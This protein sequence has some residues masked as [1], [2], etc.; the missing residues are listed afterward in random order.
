MHFLF[1]RRILATL[2]ITGSTVSAYAVSCPVY[3]GR[4]SSP[5]REAY[6]KGDLDQAA[7]LYQEELQKSPDDAAL[8]I[9]LARVLLRQ[10]KIKEAGDLVQSALGKNPNSAPL[11]TELGFIQYRAGTPWLAAASESA[12]SKLDLCNAQTH[13]LHANLLTLSSFYGSAAKELSIA[14]SLDPYDPVIAGRWLNSLPSSERIKTIE[15]SLAS[16]GGD[17]SDI[18]NLRAYLDHL[19]KEADQPHKAC[20]LVSDT[21]STEMPFAFLMENGTHIRA[22]AL[23]V[24]LNDHNAR[25]QIDTGAGG[26]VISRSVA[27][28][29][30]LKRASQSGLSGIGDRGVQ[31]GYT[32]YADDIKIGSLE[33]HD[34]EVQVLDQRNVVDSD[35][36]IGMDVFSNFLVTLDYPVR[37]LLLGPLPPRPDEVAPAKPTLQTTSST[38][39]SGDNATKD[40]SQ[41]TASNAAPRGPR[42]RYVAPEMKTWTPVY[43]VNHM[44]MLPASLNNSSVKLFILDTGAFGTTISPAVAREVTKVFADE[45]TTVN[46]ISGKVEKVYTANEITFKFA[47]LQQKVRGVVAFDTPGVSQSVGMDVAG[48][49]G[50]STLASTTMAIDY[51][52]GLVHFRYDATRGYNF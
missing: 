29:A 45:N 49:I 41:N 37:K 4:P 36:L 52:D 12:A 31:A 3:Q 28:R 6:L 47:N 44:L 15:A 7:T 43:R 17:N 26:I 40:A 51:R 46:G 18:G 16:P 11:L 27:E 13:L 48:F 14:H 30:G 8:T 33:F 23:D 1:L 35:G 20:R 39:V 21:S 19:K 24:K 25:L 34:C 22:F 9:D 42:D 38:D 2:V 50:F 5:A 32:A 10:E